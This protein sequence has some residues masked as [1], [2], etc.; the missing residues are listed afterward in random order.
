MEGKR[1]RLELGILNIKDVQFAGKTTIRDSTLYINRRELQELLQQDKRLGQVDIEL[2][3]PGEKC[4]ILQ[5]TDVI[6]PRTKISGGE[7]FPGVLSKQG[8][9]GQGST[10]VL[11]GTAVVVNDQSSVSGYLKDT[12]GDLIDMSGPGAELTPYAKTHNVVIVPYPAEGVSTEY[13]GAADYKIAIKLAGLKTAIYLA[14]AGKDVPPDETEVYDLPSLT[15]VAKGMEALP[16]VAYAFQ[17]HCTSHPALVG[18]PILYGD[19]IRRLVP[20]I[21]HPNEV[22][23]GAIVNPCHGYTIDTY[24]M[25]NHPI[26]KELY[27]KHGKELCFVGVVITTSQYQEPDRE[28]SAAITA[29]LVKSV[30]GADGVILTYVNGGAPE[31]DVAQT[32]QRCEELG[33][34]SVTIMWGIQ[35]GDSIEANIVHNLPKANAI[36]NMGNVLELIS[37]PPMERTIGKPATLP[38]GA[39]ANGELQRRAI[40]IKGAIGQLGDGKRVSVPY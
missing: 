11:R 22:L 20:T 39:P 36:V 38:T 34:K 35:D 13:I 8:T 30:L 33:V 31:V 24:V 4:R 19:N 1:L 5:V 25:Q 16:K 2:A 21:V 3:H 28:R 32:A 17:V 14:Q 10:C 15:E 27:R 40:W 9:V 12:I 23:D 29:K 26:I 7:D 18:E 37:L 6:E